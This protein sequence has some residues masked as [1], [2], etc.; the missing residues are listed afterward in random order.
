MNSFT[1]KINNYCSYLDSHSIFKNLSNHSRLNAK[2][3][4]GWGLRV[5]PSSGLVEAELTMR[6]LK[7]E[8]DQADKGNCIC[9][10]IYSCLFVTGWSVCQ[11]AGLTLLSETNKHKDSGNQDLK[12]DFGSWEALD[13]II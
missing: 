4:L 8:S 2:A 12:E 5:W 11:S 10:Q 3:L 7:E 9:V 6:P 1:Y 13:R